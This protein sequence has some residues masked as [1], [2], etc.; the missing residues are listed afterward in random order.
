MSTTRDRTR[1]ADLPGVDEVRRFA[2]PPPRESDSSRALVD[3][4]TPRACPP[5]IEAGFAGFYPRLG[6]PVLAAVL[7]RGRRVRARTSA[8]FGLLGRVR[9]SGVRRAKDVHVPIWELAVSV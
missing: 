7:S 9:E 8:K 2:S 4:S 1:A 6:A 5:R 3:S